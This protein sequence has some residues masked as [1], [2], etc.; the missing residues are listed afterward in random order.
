MAR[1]RR[2][3]VPLPRVLGDLLKLP[4][5]AFVE[6][7][8]LAYIRK[9]C[10]R[11]KGVT[12]APDAY[13]N[14]LAHYRRE[15]VR[16]RPVCFVAHTDH[17]GFVAL[18]MVD[19]RTVR[20]AFRGGVKAEYFPG[21]RVI[22]R[23]AGRWIPARV[24]ELTRIKPLKAIGWTGRPEEVLL[25]V[26]APVAAGSPGMWALPDPRLAGDTLHARGCDDV[27]GSA[28]MLALLDRLARR[29]A[30]GEV[31]CLF[32]R[33]EEV[34]FVG[35]IGAIRAATV[36]P[37]MPIVSIETSSARPTTPIGAGPILR[38]GD[39]MAVFTPALTLFLE[40]VARELSKRRKRFRF[41]RAL[42]D[43]GACE[44]SAFLAYGFEATGVCVP[45]VNYHNMDV[46]RQ[47][48]AAE[49]ISL[50][51]WKFMVD[52]FEAVVC[53]EVGYSGQ[54]RVDRQAMDAEFDCMEHLLRS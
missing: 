29:Q 8:V 51:D 18:E 49:Y 31:Y 17:P 7:E 36:P 50:A 41:Q 3:S 44:A 9:S 13:G 14:L 47:R 42:M 27:A 24:V 12:L 34:G 28:A 43:G 26:S 39:R 19:R 16:G 40:R 35:A 1:S 23:S 10:A 38:T 48:I 2:L 4:T 5:A 15:P 21:A 25:K 37:D 30:V 33:A 6:H 53:D 54:E 46:T 22:F 32:T 45:L 52:W 11:M 20:A